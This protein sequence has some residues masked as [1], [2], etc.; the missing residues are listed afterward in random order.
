MLSLLKVKYKTLVC[1]VCVGIP[2]GSPSLMGGGDTRGPCS[3][4]P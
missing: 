2:S 4:F 3:L 1:C